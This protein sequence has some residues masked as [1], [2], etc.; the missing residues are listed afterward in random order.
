MKGEGNFYV[1][2]EY[3]PQHI[4]VF[5]VLFAFICVSCIMFILLAPYLGVSFL[6]VCPV[7]VCVR[8]P[9]LLCFSTESAH[10]RWISQWSSSSSSSSVWFL[11][12]HFPPV[13]RSYF[14]HSGRK[15]NKNTFT[16]LLSIEM[17]SKMWTKTLQI[18]SRRTFSFFPITFWIRVRGG[19]WNRPENCFLSHRVFLM[20][21]HYWGWKKSILPTVLDK[22]FCPLI[23]VCT[24]IDMCLCWKDLN[25]VE[26]ALCNSWG[27]VEP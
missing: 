17:A 3:K 18:W 10:H 5:S 16:L 26:W 20:A 22:I 8:L 4:S 2:F 15:K 23:L 12:F 11:H 1:W 27:L 9:P 13:W 7:C 24:F 21:I 14:P 25:Y 19:N 6:P